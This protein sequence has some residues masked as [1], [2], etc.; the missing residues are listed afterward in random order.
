MRNTAIYAPF[1]LISTGSNVQLLSANAA[2]NSWSVNAFS[3][4]D[5]LPLGEYAHVAL[6]G[7]SASLKVYIN[8]TQFISVTQAAWASANYPLYIGGGGDNQFNG[9]IDEV[10]FTLNVARYTANFT[11]PTAP[12][13]DSGPAVSEDYYA[14]WVQQNYIWYPES[15]PPWWG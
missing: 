7:D 10:R 2:L 6:V 3:G 1:E 15:Y 4:S 8:G 11:P 9:R 5:T 12:F 14:S 13:P